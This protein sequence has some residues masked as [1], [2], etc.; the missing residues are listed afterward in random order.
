M[1]L[2]YPLLQYVIWIKIVFPEFYCLKFLEFWAFTSNFQESPLTEQYQ[3]GRLGRGVGQVDFSN[4]WK[5]MPFF[6]SRI[7]IGIP[8][9]YWNNAL[10]ISRFTR[11]PWQHGKG[12]FY[13]QRIPLSIRCVSVEAGLRPFQVLPDWLRFVQQVI[14]EILMR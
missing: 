6:L 1:L 4:R 3:N 12:V 8:W 2:E 11:E 13:L 5:R 9:K 14:R 10:K 7:E